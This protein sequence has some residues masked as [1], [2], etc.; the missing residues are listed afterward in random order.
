MAGDQVQCPVCRADLSIRGALAL[1][2]II[3]CKTCQSY[4][5]VS[6]IQPIILTYVSLA[7]LDTDE[8][9]DPRERDAV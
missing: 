2:R 3:D 4:L 5:Q 7:D 6:S 8:L 9:I 1:F